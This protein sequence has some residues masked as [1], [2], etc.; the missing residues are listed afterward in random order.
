MCLVGQLLGR[1]VMHA[2]A[3]CQSKVLFVADSGSPDILCS[4]CVFFATLE[5]HFLERLNV[6]GIIVFCSFLH[7]VKVCEE[8]SLSRT[9]SM[10][11]TAVYTCHQLYSAGLAMVSQLARQPACPAGWTLQALTMC[12][13]RSCRESCP[14]NSIDHTVYRHESRHTRLLH[15]LPM[16]V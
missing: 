16:F 14:P 6:S 11:Y 2:A 8:K 9:R 7:A 1:G 12:Y 10:Q 15:V 3:D 5:T 4:L 13:T